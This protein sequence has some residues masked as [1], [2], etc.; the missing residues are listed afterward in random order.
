MIQP[1]DERLI[2]IENSCALV[3]SKG[4]PAL[5]EIINRSLVHIQTS[6]TLGRLHRIGDHE[7][8]WPDYQLVCSWAEQLKIPPKSVLNDLL[9]QIPL[10]TRSFGTTLIDGS[11]INLVASRTLIGIK[12]L[13]AIQGLRIERLS[14][15]F[16]EKM[17]LLFSDYNSSPIPFNTGYITALGHPTEL[18]LSVIPNLKELWCLGNE[19][20][21]LDLSPVPC[22]KKL[23]C[24]SNGL[25][26]LNLSPVPN[27]MELWYSQNIITD[28]DLSPVPNLI[29]LSCVGNSGSD[30]CLLD[31][32]LSRVS[33]L[34]ELFC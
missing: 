6:K 14:F 28:L 13:P 34:E 23:V 2:R 9:E 26:E 29:G 24:A 16:R 18:D 1:E 31:L 33:M 17:D 10:H 30:A 25:F 27:L 7:L 12:G 21:Y 22:L 4:T 32:D 3:P 8:Q 15:D 20:E 19:L 5:S 11:F